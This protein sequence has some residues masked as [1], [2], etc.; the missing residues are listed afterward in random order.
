[1]CGSFIKRRLC[2]KRGSEVLFLDQ[3]NFIIGSVV[4][5]FMITE[6]TVWMLA[7]MLLITLL[8]HRIANIVGHR[9]KVKKV[10]W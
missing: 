8:V 10:P 3:W 6:I 9:L 5:I 7:M 1:M 4:F 2:F